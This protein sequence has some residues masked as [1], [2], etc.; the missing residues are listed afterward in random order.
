MTS[1]VPPVS[2]HVSVSEVDF[3]TVY[4][5]HFHAI[6]RWLSY[7]LGS[8]DGVDDLTQDAFIV[9]RRRL[10]E[11]DGRNLGG[12]LW[13]ICRLVA[14]NERRRRRR[15]WRRF[16]LSPDIMEMVGPDPRR[17]NEDR[18][19][20]A[21]AMSRL[22]DEHRTTLLLHFVEGMTAAE[23][24]SLLGV[25]DSTIASRIREGQ[26]RFRVAWQRLDEEAE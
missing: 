8:R 23:I 3:A 6:Q 19:A 10:A 1:Q 21:A 5:A 14:S 25:P 4:D 7:L 11:F 22:S 15:F 2:D 24:S 12:W 18:A 20:V 16:E 26:K 9:I 13:S 17:A